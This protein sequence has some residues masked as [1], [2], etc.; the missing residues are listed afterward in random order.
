MRICPDATVD[1][2]MLDVCLVGDISRIEALRQLPGL[3][4]GRHVRHPAVR[5]LRSRW[6]E[7]R[8]VAGGGTRTHLDG[9]PFGPLPLR[10]DV[11]PRA[12]SVA[13]RE[14]S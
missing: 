4:R 11:L 7:L 5:M 14:A 3:Y 1:D 9:E 10:V 13:V 12:L 8:E 2:G 6:I